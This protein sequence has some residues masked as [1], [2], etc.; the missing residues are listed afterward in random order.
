VQLKEESLERI[1]DLAGK[2][3]QPLL[4]VT[5]NMLMVVS[6]IKRTDR[7]IHLISN[8][9]LA[10]LREIVIPLLS[11]R[12]DDIIVFKDFNIASG[13]A[14]Q[15]LLKSMEESRDTK[16][17]FL[18]TRKT[19]LK[20]FLSRCQVFDIVSGVPPDTG[21]DIKNLK[22]AVLDILQKDKKEMDNESKRVALDDKIE[23]LLNLS[24]LSSKIIQ[25]L[26][27]YK[28]FLKSNCN[29]KL[30]GSQILWSLST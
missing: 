26:L 14:Q 10:T 11:S 25:D 16:M 6:Y 13:E 28:R 22:S 3:K 18:A 1:T 24:G 21:Q 20:T 8:Y 9:D 5:Q 2:N 7:R 15:F 23:E 29:I 30:I 4:I 27:T 17:I 19:F 12:G